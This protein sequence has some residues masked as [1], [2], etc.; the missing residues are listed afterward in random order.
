MLHPPSQNHPKTPT[1]PPVT[2][3]TAFP[4]KAPQIRHRTG[5][6]PFGGDPFKQTQQFGGSFSSTALRPELALLPSL[7]LT[8]EDEADWYN[9]QKLPRWQPFSALNTHNLLPKKGLFKS[10]FPTAL[11]LIAFLITTIAFVF[12]TIGTCQMGQNILRDAESPSLG[13]TTTATA[14]VAT[15][16]EA[17]TKTNHIAHQYAATVIE[18]VHPIE[19]KEDATFRQN[20]AISFTALAQTEKSTPNKVGYKRADPLKPSI[21]LVKHFS[22]KDPTDA[23]SAKNTQG[24]YTPPSSGG[25]GRSVQPFPATNGVASAATLTRV[26]ARVGGSINIE[27][28]PLPPTIRFVGWVQS[29][30]DGRTVALIEVPNGNSVQTLAKPLNKSFSLDG[31]TVTLRKIGTSNQLEASVG[32]AKQVLGLETSGE[33][34]KAMTRSASS[35]AG[36]SISGKPDALPPTEKTSPLSDEEL[37]KLLKQVNQP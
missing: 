9:T 15:Q 23:G 24:Y 6:P 30:T 17:T 26:G 34:L 4:A 25:G 2:T 13:N 29:K 18:G 20:E 37:I 35:S 11:P 22:V 19:A 31:K 36:T 33:E 21:E 27:E 14:L 1:L 3:G 5:S 10:F 12:L 8:T 28:E 7:T 32:G 16:K